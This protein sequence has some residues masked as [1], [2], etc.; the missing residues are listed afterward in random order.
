LTD[1]FGDAESREKESRPFAFLEVAE[2]QRQ[3]DSE[4]H[5]EERDMNQGTIADG[6]TAAA[7]LCGELAAL[8]AGRVPGVPYL[9]GLGFDELGNLIEALPPHTPDMEFHRN[10]ARSSR[11]LWDGDEGQVAS[12]QLTQMQRRLGRQRAEWS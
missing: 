5:K 12:Y 6:I 8:C 11:E 9:I 2:P 7:T 3:P 1:P 10:W 4:K